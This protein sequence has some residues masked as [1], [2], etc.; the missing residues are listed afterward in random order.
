MRQAVLIFEQR[1]RASR[2]VGSRILRSL[3]AY[4]ARGVDVKGLRDGSDEGGESKEAVNE[5]FSAVK[6]G[7]FVRLYWH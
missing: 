4:F 6:S 7:P 2:A 1:H 3:V 5:A